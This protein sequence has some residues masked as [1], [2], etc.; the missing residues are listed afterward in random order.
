M[1]YLGHSS[2]GTETPGTV[3]YD[4]IPCQ[5]DVYSLGSPTYNWKTLYAGDVTTETVTGLIAPVGATD[6]TNKAYVD[7]RRGQAICALKTPNIFGFTLPFPTVSSLE[8]FGPTIANK[9]GLSRI[10]LGNE[11]IYSY[12]VV[13]DNTMSPAGINDIRLNT[14]TLTG[15]ASTICTSPSFPLLGLATN[16]GLTISGQVVI[17]SGWGTVATQVNSNIIVNYSITVGGEVN[18]VFRSQTAF[19]DTT[20]GYMDFGVVF[21]SAEALAINPCDMDLF[22][23]NCDLTPVFSL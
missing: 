20:V 10:T 19:I 14:V 1:D 3:C 12:K 13:C 4:I 18:N 5:D 17:V 16:S 2:L 11:S 15:N 22:V 8:I 7:T 21:N 9:N 6:A 23:Y